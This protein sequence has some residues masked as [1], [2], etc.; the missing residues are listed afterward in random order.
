MKPG[1]VLDAVVDQHGVDVIVELLS[2]RR[3]SVLR[4]DDRLKGT[5]G[6][7][8]IFA[9]ASKSGGYCLVVKAREDADAGSFQV[10]LAARRQAGAADRLRAAGEEAFSRAEVQRF[11]FLRDAVAP[12]QEA[13]ADFQ[14]LGLRDRA[15]SASYWLGRV[16]FA[17]GDAPSALRFLGAAATAWSGRKEEAIALNASAFPFAAMGDSKSGFAAAHRAQEIAR[18]FGDRHLEAGIYNNLGVVY[19][20]RGELREALGAFA[21]AIAEWRAEPNPRELAKSL[22]N[23]AELHLLVG[24]P[25]DALAAANEAVTIESGRHD[26]DTEAPSLRAQGR[27]FARLDRRAEALEALKSALR[28]DQQMGL[29][30]E[31]VFALLAIG[32]EELDS[33]ELKKAHETFD[34]ALTA[35]QVS[36]QDQ[37]VAGALDRLGK[38]QGLEGDGASGLKLLGQAEDLY[39]RLGDSESVA[40]SRYERALILY[41]SRH[42]PEALA[43]LE[44]ALPLLE[45]LRLQPGSSASRASFIASHHDI[46]ELD[47]DLRMQL[48]DVA[49]AFEVSERARARAILD[50]LAEARAKIRIGVD[51]ALLG[52]QAELETRL[53]WLDQHRTKAEADP[54][55]GEIQ[56]VNAELAVIEANIRTGSPK[57]ASLSK[58]PIES[59]AAVQREIL[60]E[61][62]ALLAYSLGEERS[63]LWLIRRGSVETRELPAKKEIERLAHAV[64]DSFS[65]APQRAKAAALDRAFSQ[66]GRAVLGPVAGALGKD[67]LLIVADGALQRVPFAALPVPSPLGGVERPLLFDHEIVNLPSASVLALLRQET[68]NRARPPKTVAVLGD[69]VYNRDD[70]RLPEAVRRAPRVAPAAPLGDLERSARDLGIAGFDRLPASKEEADAILRLVPPGQGLEALGFDANRQ[71]A[72]SRELAQYQVVHYATHAVADLPHPELSGIVLSLFDSAGRS[73]NGFLRAYE[74]Y[75]LNLPVDLV[76]LSACRTA[77]GPEIRGEGLSGLTR[78]FMYAGAPRV[79]VSLWNVSD[80]GTARLMERFYRNLLRQGMRPAA[81]LRAAQLEML[82]DAAWKAP[83]YWAGFI[84]QGEWR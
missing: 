15:A 66:L 79:L 16:H 62:T 41:R 44:T 61:D 74:I 1:Q 11:S 75:N 31:E 4:V 77:V 28:L 67:R 83:Y 19:E 57:Y 38:V 68:A 37:L 12:Y 71:L 65:Q 36:R 23:I 59:L 13:L 45:T 49:G 24:Q 30:S 9:V 55:A 70:K 48:H 72:T 43:V 50:E 26:A 47:V 52:R 39:G 5:E 35:A 60:D 20:F 25:E 2:P 46:F 51:P 82:Q 63:Y 27:A 8:T 17:L 10:V 69:G 84:L 33:G 53:A 22:T 58:P 32:T 78:G 80:K 14:K 18:R 40:A 29:R 64:I 73:Q 6:P 34:Q 21:S 7:E 76:V 54:L 81:A 56:S 42:F 3:K